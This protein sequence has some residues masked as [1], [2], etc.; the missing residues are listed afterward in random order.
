MSS[1]QSRQNNFAAVMF[2]DVVAVNAAAAPCSPPIHHST[3]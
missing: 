1:S 3:R 2:R